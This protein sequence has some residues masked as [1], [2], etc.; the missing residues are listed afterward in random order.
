MIL[1]NPLI[2]LLT[3]RATPGTTNQSSP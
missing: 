3:Q 2:E 1:L